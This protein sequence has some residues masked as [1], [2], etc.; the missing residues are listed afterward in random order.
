MPS[1]ALVVLLLLT[2]LAPSIAHPTGSAL[3]AK[4]LTPPILTSRF[5]VRAGRSPVLLSPGAGIFADRPV[6][7]ALKRVLQF[8]L[9]EPELI[10]WVSLHPR[11]GPSGTRGPP[12]HVAAELGI[13]HA[14]F[15]PLTRRKKPLCSLALRVHAALLA[16]EILSVVPLAAG[17]VAPSCRR[18]PPRSSPWRTSGPRLIAREFGGRPLRGR[19]S[20][21]KRVAATRYFLGHMTT[22]DVVH[23]PERYRATLNPVHICAAKVRRS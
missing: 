7:G 4:P 19:G 5:S 14:A 8:H 2:G 1:S 3:T 21:S 10:K 18:L 17:T 22:S 11:P 16:A 15:L 20:I 9:A 13:G 23:P 12:G 6:D